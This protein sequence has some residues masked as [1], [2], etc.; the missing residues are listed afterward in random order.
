MRGSFSS[1]VIGPIYVQKMRETRRAAGNP[2]YLSISGEPR[3]VSGVVPRF[4]R[5]R[6]K[7]GRFG[8]FLGSKSGN[9]VPRF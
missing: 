9:L 2:K 4:Q 3:D 1:G 7:K 6:E 8:A 5:K